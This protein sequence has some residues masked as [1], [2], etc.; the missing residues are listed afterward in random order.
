[1]SSLFIPSF[2]ILYFF[3]QFYFPSSF[4]LLDISLSLRPFSFQLQFRTIL[5]FSVFPPSL[6]VP[7]LL[8]SIFQAIIPPSIL[9]PSLPPSP[10]VSPFLS[11]LRS[12]LHL[13]C[14][15]LHPCMYLTHFF[16]L[17]SSS[18]SCLPSFFHPYPHH[19]LNFIRPYSF[20]SFF[21]FSSSSPYYSYSFLVKG[22]Q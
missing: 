12:Y 14:C 6:S 2:F 11:S 15:F 7:L 3:S 16:S 5:S 20:S 13:S 18:T 19:H 10:C 22:A 17:T 1:M 8:T 4:P 21:L 9:L